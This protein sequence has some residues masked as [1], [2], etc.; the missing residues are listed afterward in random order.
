M[1]ALADKS[2][3]AYRTPAVRDLAWACFSQ[4]LLRSG[5]LPA[6]DAPLGNCALPLTPTRL[7]WLE[8]LDR[9]PAPLLQ[10]LA[11]PTS[12]RLGLYFERLWHFFLTQDEDVELVAHNLPVHE[13]GRTVG[14]FDCLYYCRQRQKH[15]H[16]ELA[17]K[18]YLQLPG[19][20]GGQWEHWV[21]PNR[22]DR[23]DLKLRRLLQHQLQLGAHPAA[24]PL[25]DTLGIGT[26]H[27]E[28]EMKG[29]LFQHQGSDS[30]LPSGCLPS[31]QPSWHCTLGK[32]PH[33]LSH[34]AYYLPLAR[35]Q[36]FAPLVACD[37]HELLDATQL[38]RVLDEAQAGPGSARPALVALVDAHGAERE[39]F[40]VVPDV[41]SNEG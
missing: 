27:R 6:S 3:L 5:A 28:L 11:E 40:F 35:Q 2:T 26:V 23:L 16:L 10:R 12:T 34:S 14:E 13:R 7:A 33:Y 15:V 41:W 39:R 22:Q 29:R 4:P 20:D 8:S 1:E 9:R 36:W 25:L 32:L 31:V 24:L 21:G 19:T 37:H 18:F 38:Q 30:L 17:V